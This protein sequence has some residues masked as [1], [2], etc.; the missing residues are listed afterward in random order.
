M[1]RYKKIFFLT[2][3]PTKNAGSI[4]EYFIENTEDFIAFHFFPSYTN[5]FSYTEHY[6]NGKKIFYKVFKH[7][8][9]GNRFVKNII[10]FSAFSYTLLF[11]VKRGS[12]IIVNAPIY[13]F[14]SSI[15]SI[16]K[17]FQ[18]V[19][20]I[21]DYYP[22]KKFPMNIYH[23]IVDYYN[24]QLP[25]VLY[26]SPPINK[27]Y[28]NKRD[29]TKFSKMV[30][31][32]IKREISLKHASNIKNIRLG[33]IGIIR[34]QQGLELVFKFLQQSNNCRLDVVGDG[35]RLPYYKGLAKKLGINNKVTFHGRVDDISTMFSQWDIALAL[36]EESK[37]N[38]SFYCEPTKIKHY[39]SYGLPVITTKTTY[40]YKELEE[41]HAGIVVDESVKSLEIAIN[42]ILKN[43]DH[44]KRG[45]EGLVNKYEYSSWYDKRLSFLQ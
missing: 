14:F 6:K 34:E 31:L 4:K 23:K 21:G 20:W 32:G 22:Q 24:N 10:D 19:L 37:M 39:L 36:Y 26:L 18:Y 8:T 2:A 45:V 30:P 3:D 25:Y 17:S 41:M 38:L 40:F 43:Y 9:G 16:L 5:E 29:K 42:K 27:I 7:Y 28:A 11:I 12:F 13:C 44:Y 15:F 33:F 35:Y 1:A